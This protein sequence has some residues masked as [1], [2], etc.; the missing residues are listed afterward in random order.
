MSIRALAR[1]DSLAASLFLVVSACFVL[2]G[3]YA[4]WQ[5]GWTE[6]YA[7]QWR[8]YRIYLERD[9]PANVLVLE[10]GHRPI[11]PAILRVLEMYWLHGNQIL[12]LATGALLA[13]AT[14]LLLSLAVWRDTTITPLAK[15]M[16]IAT[17][18]MAIFWM[19]NARYLL[20]G[21]ESVHGYLLTTSLVGAMLLVSAERPSRGRTLAASAL[22][23]VATFCF[24]PGLAAFVAIAT[25]CIVQ[26]HYRSLPWLAAALVATLIIYFA[27]PGGT[28]VR[29]R[30][31]FDLVDTILTTA[32]WLCSAPVHLLLGFL[33]PNA[34]NSL[35]GF[36]KA[37][38]NVTASTYEETFG[39]IWTH[40]G[41]VAIVGLTAISYIVWAT[42]SAWHKQEWNRLLLLGLGLAW[43]AIAAAGIV[44]LARADYFVQHRGQIF[45]NRFLPWSCLFWLSIA[46]TAL[47]R[48]QLYRRA[49]ARRITIA[50]IG[51]VLFLGLATTKGHLWWGHHVQ[52][53]IRLTATGIAV[54]VLPEN[55]G[56]YG[57]TLLSEV[58]AGRPSVQH[59]GLSMFFWPEA[60]LTGRML[61]T[62]TQRRTQVDSTLDAR[63]IINVLN[64]TPAV[65]L[66][67]RIPAPSQTNLPERMLALDA[68][69]IVIGILSHARNDPGHVYR[70][71]SAAA[72]TDDIRKIVSL[73]KDGQVECYYGC[74]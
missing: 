37:I 46:W 68:D 33:D 1:P 55:G 17:A 15:G 27:L 42:F 48:S 11:F 34:G 22:A 39:S 30:L 24:G 12:Q 25:L 21:N 65:E 44:A 40:Y 72:S 10:N 31:G 61:A 16:A 66:I 53:H 71:Y 3:L 69:G 5:Y 67:L 74:E 9:F 36:L 19:G 52:Q 70:G 58:V 14:W 63:S 4:I 60:A 38:T 23:F 29:D 6:I 59:A 62:S 73:T 43:F 57:E 56:K 35:P 20:H 13:L 2:I 64:D 49:I 28:G 8:L 7:D 41:H 50:S 26:R 54:G 45:S 51:M 18:A 32:I 47:A